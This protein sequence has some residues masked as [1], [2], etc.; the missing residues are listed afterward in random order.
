MSRLLT[1]LSAKRIPVVRLAMCVALVA[2]AFVTRLSLG[3]MFPAGSLIFSIFYLAVVIAAYFAGPRLAAV[4]ALVAAVSAYWAFAAPGF[5]WKVNVEALISM[6]FFALTSAVDIY[7]IT[8]MKRAVVRYRLERTRA[9]LL[10]QGH[11]ALF[12]EYNER[13]A[14]HLQLLGSLLRGGDEAKLVDEAS[15]RTLLLSSV[16]RALTAD[17]AAEPD[18]AAFAAQLVDRFLESAHVRPVTVVVQGGPAQVTPD[19]AASMAM[20][21]SEWL[22]LALPRLAKAY[23][24]HI[25]I[26]IAQEE[27]AL[28]ASGWV[29]RVEAPLTDL[30]ARIVEAV[31]EHLGGRHSIE[32]APGEL[33]FRLVRPT[34]LAS[35]PSAA[36]MP[37]WIAP[38]SASL[39]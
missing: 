37:I 35:P 12:H 8:G 22:R 10:A 14:N 11:A 27:F 24:P 3:E 32:A 17:P 21:L 28:R 33:R 39:Q 15:R 13:T 38:G 2:A 36:G 1:P 34:G 29:T 19:R 31:A 26:V 7:F 30:S 9:E 6:G 18:F 25:E 16:H 20:L 5:A 4:T 23:Q